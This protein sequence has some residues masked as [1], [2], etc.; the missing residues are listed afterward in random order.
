MFKQLQHSNSV[1]NFIMALGATFC[2][3]KSN[4]LECHRYLCL[5]L[6]DQ[7]INSLLL[8]D[9]IIAGLSRYLKVWWIYFIP[10]KAL[11]FG[12]G[13]DR[14]ENVLWRTEHLLIPPSLNNVVVL[15][16]T[17]N[18][19]TDSPMDIADCVVNIGSCLRE[20]SS[21]MNVFLCGLIPRDERCSVNKVLIKDIN[22]ILKYLCL[23][24]DFLYIEKRNGWTLPNSDLDP[25]LV[26]R[27]S[28]HLIKEGNVKF[29]K[30][31]IN[32]IALT[33]NTCFSSKTDK[34]CSCSDTS[35]NKVSTPFALTLTEAD[36]PALS[37]PVHAHKCK[38]SPYLIICETHGTNYVSS[39]S[40]P[41]STKTACKP[42]RTVSCNKHVIFSPI[43]KFRHASNICISKS[44]RFNV[45]CKSFVTCKTVCFSNVSMVKEFTSVNYCLVSY[46][47]WISS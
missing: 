28:L 20:K 10:L 11:N 29:A 2:F 47:Y 1:G 45:N 33:N 6:N 42:A 24:H 38:N 5:I 37:L 31:I 40:K 8:G 27:D 34:M 22:R 32:S 25:S 44:V 23:K 15:C 46:F 13:R 41:V 19:F 16:G 12:I 18:L 3:K 14:V 9:S 7:F 36:F 26:F 30:F 21:S 39:T 43:S 35:K 17:N 4:G